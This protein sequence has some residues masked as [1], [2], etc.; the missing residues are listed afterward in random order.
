MPLIHCILYHKNLVT[1]LALV[2]LLYE[3]CQNSNEPPSTIELS[4][5]RN[6]QSQVL[7]LTGRFGTSM[8]VFRHLGL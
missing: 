8:S 2:G 5:K 4:L 3:E 1:Q 7:T 6:M